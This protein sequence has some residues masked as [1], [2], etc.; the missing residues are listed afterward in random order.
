[1][2]K[3]LQEKDKQLQ[4]SISKQTDMEQKLFHLNL[5]EYKQKQE[6]ERLLKVNLKLLIN[7]F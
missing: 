1:M 4:E 7:N 2:E 3:D 5:L 6:N